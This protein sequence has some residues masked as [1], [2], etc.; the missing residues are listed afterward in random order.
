MSSDRDLIPSL[1]EENGGYSFTG[2][3][4]RKFNMP[5]V[6]MY[7]VN[8]SILY[9]GFS[10]RGFQRVFQAA[11][12]SS[13]KAREECDKLS[14]WFCVSVE[15][16]QKLEKLL[17]SRL[18]PKYNRRLSMVAIAERLGITQTQLARY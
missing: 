13:Q 5:C 11:H 15:A 2:T 16:A 7:S 3:D 8:D 6:Y 4:V 17:I 9:V 14:V 18:R 10:R 12:R 1:I